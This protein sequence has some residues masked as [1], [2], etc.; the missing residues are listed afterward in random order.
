LLDNAIYCRVSTDDQYC[1]RQ[2][3]DFWAFAR[4]AG[5]QIVR[6]FKE[7]ASP[8]RHGQSVR[9]QERRR[10]KLKNNQYFSS[11]DEL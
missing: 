1:A 9:G 5:H 6:V 8:S 10:T 7:T 2:E 4:R 11:L 3:R